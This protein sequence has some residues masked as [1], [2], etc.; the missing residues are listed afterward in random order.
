MINPIILASVGIGVGVVGMASSF[1]VWYFARLRN[2]VLRDEMLRLQRGLY[3]KLHDEISEEYDARRLADFDVRDYAYHVGEKVSGDLR[4][5]VIATAVLP[6][7]VPSTP[8]TQATE[9]AVPPV[10]PRI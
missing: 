3:I 7:S 4:E 2:A 10:A 6:V 8:P 9:A 5:H 1:V